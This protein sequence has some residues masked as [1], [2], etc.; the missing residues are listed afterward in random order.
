MGLVFFLW[1]L[2]DSLPVNR[3]IAQLPGIVLLRV[4]S[5]GLYFFT[6]SWL[7]AALITLDELLND[8]PQKAVYLRLATIFF[9]L[10]AILL[11]VVIVGVKPDKNSFILLH[12]ACWLIVAAVII[13]YSYRKVSGRLFLATLGLF[14][15]ADLAMVDIRLAD[16]IPTREALSQGKPAADYL[17]SLGGDFRVFSPSYSIPQQ[18]AAFKGI[19]LADGIDPLQIKTYSDFVRKAAGFSVDGYSV[20]LPPYESG[21]PSVDNA[22]IQ[23]NAE[24]F[25]LLNVKYMV[26]AFPVNAAGWTLKEKTA[27]AYVYENTVT[28]GWAWMEAA[29]TGKLLMGDLTLI[30]RN[31]F[32]I[33]LTADGP[34]RLVVS[35]IAY[36]GWQVHVDGQHADM[37]IAHG[38]LRAVDLSGGKHSVEFT[39]APKSIYAGLAISLLSLIICGFLIRRQGVHG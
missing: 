5:R 15:V 26:S 31:P 16:Y 19:Q 4:P 34:G 8:N 22:G 37:A 2:G 7:V 29:D 32:T 21:D 33:R 39:F 12:T 13:T 1:A 25:G 30:K 17:K 10:M 3:F 28:H 38:I 14:A 36:P 9:A 11:Q 18:T 6:V 23:P 27:D 35:D 20:T 24:A